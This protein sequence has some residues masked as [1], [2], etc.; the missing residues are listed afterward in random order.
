MSVEASERVALMTGAGRG[1]GRVMTLALLKRR[2][3]NVR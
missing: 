1:L 2:S 3:D